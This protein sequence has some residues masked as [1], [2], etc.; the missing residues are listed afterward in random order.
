MPLRTDAVL[1]SRPLPQPRDL[2]M[3]AC[4]CAELRHAASADELWKPLFDSEFGDRPPAPASGRQGWKGAFGACWAT[5]ARQRRQRR[6]LA[7][8]PLGG[9]L[10]PFPFGV[11]EEMV[12]GSLCGAQRHMRY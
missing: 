12:S 4:V 8:A 3:A 5:R 9:P 7:G 10:A 1:T 11:R 6:R 2:A